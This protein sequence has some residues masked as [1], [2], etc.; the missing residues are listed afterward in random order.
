MLALFSEFHRKT[1]FG[2]VSNFLGKAWKVEKTIFFSLILLLSIGNIVKAATRL[3]PGQYADIQLAVHDCN[4]G[5]VV[6]VETG[7]Y[8][9][10]INFSGKNIILTSIDP[11][12]P[13]VVAGT[14][15]DADADGS[16]VTFENGETSQAVLT[17]FTITGGF[18]TLNTDLGSEVRILWGGGVYCY[19]AS[20]TITNNIFTANNAPNEIFGDTIEDLLFGYGAAIGGLEA[21][22]II[23]RNI[24]TGNT[25]YAG[26]GI[27][28][29]GDPVIS[30]NLIYDNSAYVGGGVIMAGGSLSNNTIA[31]N[32]ASFQGG[33]QAG[34]NVHIVFDPFFPSTRI[35]NNNI[36]F[37]ARSG[38]GITWEG[39]YPGGLIEFNNVWN[40]TP[41]NYGCAAPGAVEL[42]FGG[43]ADHTGIDG[44][45]SQDPLFVDVSTDDYH[46]QTGSPC[47]NAGDTGIVP[48]PGETDFDGELRMYATRI[49]I[50]ADE[51]YGYV[52]PVA[53]AGPDQ[54]VDGPELITLDGAGSFFYDPDGIM[55][56]SWEQVAGSAVVMSDFAASRPTILPESEGEYHFQLVVS[57]GLNIS[58][59]DEVIIIVSNRDSLVDGI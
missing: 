4:D 21:N 2:I 57:D 43:Q 49:D 32:D 18:G 55:E 50:G 33:T 5:D 29:A 54:H 37:G 3:V 51:Y 30:N 19:R 41:D 23:T 25:A 7:T 17:G 53:N 39:D 48:A 15:I 6:I 56:F 11:N 35:L 31:L 40:N 52:K 1:Q 12:D 38:G 42:T 24:I 46:L 13:N 14:V 9:E 8:Y 36:I 58:E 22:P 16:V 34:G 20:P 59:P 10:T 26:A 45:I 28:I 47:I 44:N 27:F